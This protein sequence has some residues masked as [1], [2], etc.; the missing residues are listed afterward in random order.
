MVKIYQAGSL[1]TTALTVP[2]LYVQIVPPQTVLNGVPSNRLGIVGT[3]SWG[4]V[5]TPVIIGGM[6]DYIASFGA[7]QP[8]TTNIGTA[9]NVALLQGATDFRCSRVTDGTDTAAV[10]PGGI[11]ISG[12]S[13]VT[14]TARCTGSLGNSIKWKIAPN[15]AGTKAVLSVALAPM[16]ITETFVIP[17]SSG[18]IATTDC[19][20]AVNG[21]DGVNTA[22]NL[23]VAGAPTA[24]ATSVQFAATGG[25]A[26][27]GTDGG[28]PSTVQFIGTD[29]TTTRT[30][31]YSL[32]G[33]GCSI[34]LL[35]GLTDPSSWTAQQAFGLGEGTYMVTSFA[36]GMSISNAVSGLASAGV[37]G[38]YSLKVMHGDWLYWNDDTNG[39]ML[40]P[41]SFWA[42]GRLAALS[43]EQSS[44]NKQ[45]Y[46]VVG[47]QK[48]GLTS[49]SQALTYSDAELT[50][51]FGVGI[52][53]IAN[54]SPGGSYWSCRLGHNTSSSAAVS[55]D[56]YT[57]LTNYIAETLATGM[58]VYIG[59]VINDGLFADVRATLLGF[60]KTMLDAGLLGLYGGTIPY[61]VVCDTSNNS[62]ARTALGYL[63]ADVAVRY[64]GIVEKF[65]VNLQGGTTVTVTTSSGSV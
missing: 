14:L 59:E 56:N 44:L 45:L 5:N 19:I 25:G 18:K 17:L 40:L 39:T 20:A 13:I 28:I 3:A 43:P 47:S 42:A 32:R 8:L 15:S 23:F 24:G 41:P 26:N 51:L 16:G 7:K 2:N 57:R 46:G 55:G 9:V 21:T 49:T 30:G 58:G 27:G 22:S 64:Q 48:S 52:D 65:I 29:A 34:G 60:L 62:Q 12:T 6:G 53:V 36:S 4:P 37:T 61:T 1:N 31:M 63:Q 38:S 54:P 11:N 10:V 50:A 33:T 35:A